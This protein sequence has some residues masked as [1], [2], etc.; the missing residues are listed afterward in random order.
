MEQTFWLTPVIPAIQEVE[1]SQPGQKVRETPS[2][3]IKKAD[4]GGT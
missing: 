4:H 3:L 2:Q 1:I